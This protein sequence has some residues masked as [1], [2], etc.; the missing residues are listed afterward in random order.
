M[1]VKS[2]DGK[3]RKKKHSGILP[4]EVIPRGSYN[5]TESGCSVKTVELLP[6]KGEKG[7]IK[8]SIER[9]GDFH[10]FMS[11]PLYFKNVLKKARV[12][13]MIISYLKSN[14]PVCVCL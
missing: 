11:L 7:V 3:G 14:L 2:V 8:R 5:E 6:I 1:F 13:V 9:E 10:L 12:C 4:Y